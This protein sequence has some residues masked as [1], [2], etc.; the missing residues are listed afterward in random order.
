MIN[1]LSVIF[2]VISF[3]FPSNEKV[4]PSVIPRLWIFVL[5][6]LNLITLI[7]I[8]RNKEAVDHSDEQQ[9][10]VYQFIGLLIIYL[11]SIYYIG[12]FISSFIF[13]FMGIYML[14]YRKYRTM[15]I[16]SAGWLIFS[17]FIF[18]KLLFVPLPVGKLI[19]MMF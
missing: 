17:Y 14:G 5:I 2:F 19:E 1:F 4:G 10:T 9:K 6:P 11:I 15:L 18:Y 12:Y 3:S 16:I 8:F 13:L 7:N